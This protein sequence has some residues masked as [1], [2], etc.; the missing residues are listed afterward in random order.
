MSTSPDN[1]KTTSYGLPENNEDIKIPGEKPPPTPLNE[2][3]DLDWGE[4]YVE[5]ETKCVVLIDKL[6]SHFEALI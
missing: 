4:K 1:P 3:L 5:T 2:L 6:R